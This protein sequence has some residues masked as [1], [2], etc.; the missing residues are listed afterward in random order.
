MAATNASSQNDLASA[1]GLD[2]CSGGICHM[3]GINLKLNVHR[4]RDRILESFARYDRGE[5]NQQQLSDSLR[6]AGVHL[7]HAY[8]LALMKPPLTLAKLHHAL[9]MPD[10]DRLATKATSV[11]KAADSQPIS[12][13][14]VRHP[15]IF[16]KTWDGENSRLRANQGHVSQ[17]TL[18]QLFKDLHSGLSTAADVSRALIDRGV[19]INAR[20]HRL[21]LN[22]ERGSENGFRELVLEFQEPCPHR[23][24]LPR[25]C[26]SPRARAVTDLLLARA[27]PSG[28]VP[29]PSILP[30]HARGLNRN[31]KSTPN[32]LV[33]G[34][35]TSNSDWE[36][37][38][39]Q[40]AELKRAHWYRTQRS[41]LIHSQMVVPRV[42]ESMSV[43][44]QTRQALS[45]PILDQ[46]R[47]GDPELVGMHMPT[48]E[49]ST[50]PLSTSLPRANAADAPKLKCPWGND[51]DIELLPQPI[52]PWS[53]KLRR[54]ET[55][56]LKCCQEMA[57]L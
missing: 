34:H 31:E 51:I 19:E 9:T 18:Q 24:E 50:P 8:Y 43:P 12:F 27:A 3:S 37:R 53:S 4:H 44:L 16:A 7:T 1:S 28:P 20:R 11:S 5:T 13:D 26:H 40:L 25:E 52:R 6:Q 23:D 49:P 36:R 29:R 10:G 57:D 32:L 56:S 38:N 21:L 2:G 39:V 46:M 22:C 41:T 35:H 42:M 47:I 54:Y 17:S 30:R 45:D 15:L 14:H 33:W 48:P 55:L